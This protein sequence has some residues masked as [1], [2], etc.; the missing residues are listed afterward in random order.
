MLEFVRKHAKSWLA[1]VL[2]GLIIVVFIFWG[3]YTYDASRE[4]EMAQV[5]DQV[6][7]VAEYN[8]AYSTM[9]ENYRRQMGSAFSED[10]IRKLNLKKATMDALIT[11]ALVMRGAEALGLSATTDEV[12]RRILGFSMFLNEGMFEKKRYEAILREMRMT[13]ETFERQITQ[14]VTTRK[15][16]AFIKNRAVVTD[17]EIVTDHHFYRDQVRIAYVL[18]DPKPL[19]DQVTVDEASL[20]TF[21]QNNQ[22]RYMEPERREIASVLLSFEELGKDIPASDDEVKRHYEDHLAQYKREKE[23]RAR[24]ILIMVKEGA[25]EKEVEKARSEAQKVLDEAK[26][27]KDFAELAKKYS[28]DTTTAK[29]GGDLDYF[30][31]KAMAP[32][33]SEAAFAL[34][35]GQIGS[36]VKTP[37][38]FHI[39][40][41]EDVREA[42]TVPL[43]EVKADIAKLLKTQVAQEIAFKKGREF[44]DL[45]YARKDIEKAAQEMKLGPVNTT[46]IE[47]RGEGPDS[48]MLTP[49][50]K[51]KL[52]E[53]G[54][55]DVSDAFELPG[56]F[57]VAQ[58]KTIQ[59][60]RPM[61]FE[62]VKEKVTKDYR[63]EQSRVLARNKAADLLK[64]AKEK[65]SLAT[66][67]KQFNL[68]ARQSESFSR[69]E[70]DKDLKLLR[71]ENLNKVFDLKESSPFP[72]SPLDLGNRIVVC[73]LLGMTPAGAPTQEDVAAI[74]KRILQLKQA[75]VWQAWQSDLR[76]NTKIEIFKEL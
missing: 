38:G 6:I 62:Q 50:I 3:G 26:K 22:A 10:L 65:N 75:A 72:E 21:H 18:F 9:I 48:A 33:F 13:P 17:D 15:V 25:S 76:K 49:Q 55:G 47:L 56:G 63:T 69:Q 68:S 73:Q 42:R 2:F 12:R 44:R 11:Q 39:I 46:W 51:G 54:R 1:K 70:P 59:A 32:E 40:K 20:R 74:S 60:T 37:Y 36:L 67:A 16:E 4:T 45:A 8:A 14:D 71:G 19:E 31:E 35:K 34:K 66:A 30:N 61:P 53:L 57:I 64:A 58:L 41:V 29:Q 28:Q 43:A 7:G 5:G 27:G 23:V 24:H 52:F